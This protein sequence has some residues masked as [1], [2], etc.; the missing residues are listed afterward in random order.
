MMQTLTQLTQFA[1][2][3]PSISIVAGFVLAVGVVY[4]YAGIADRLKGQPRDDYERFDF[5]RRTKVKRVLFGCVACTTA[6]L[7][8]LYYTGYWVF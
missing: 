7:L 3:Y 4:S 2:E 6:G 8:L 5:Y 1:A